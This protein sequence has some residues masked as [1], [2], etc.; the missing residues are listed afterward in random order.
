MQRW[1]NTTIDRLSIKK[2]L[3]NAGTYIVLILAVGGLMFF[4]IFPPQGDQGSLSGTAAEVGDLRIS[5]NDFRAAYQNTHQTYQNQYGQDFDPGRLNLSAIVLNQLVDRA[6]LFLTA[7]ALGVQASEEDVI[8]YLTGIDAFRDKD[9]NFSERYYASFLRSNRYSEEVFMTNIVRDLTLSQLRRFVTNFVFVSRGE[10]E[11]DYRLANSHLDVAFIKIEAAQLNI[12]VSVA[13]VDAYLQTETGKQATQTYFDE[14][15][16]AFKQVEQVQAQHILIA[17]QEARNASGAG[18]KRSKAE[19]QVLATKVRKLAL[20]GAFGALAQ[21]YSDE[22][23]AK[24]RQGDLGFFTREDMAAPFSRAAFALA[25]G[26]ISAVTETDFGFHVIKVLAKK[27]AVEKDF[28]TA[29]PEIG[30]KLLKKERGPEFAARLAQDWLQKLN[31]AI[32]ISQELSA[33]GLKLETTG[34]FSLSAGYVPKL[35]SDTELRDLVYG[36]SSERYALHEQR[37]DFYLL[38]LKAKTLADVKNFKD[39]RSDNEYLR[40]YRGSALYTWLEKHARQ[41]LEARNEISLNNAFLHFD[42]RRAA[43]NAAAQADES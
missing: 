42:Q 24:E 40:F 26:E 32:D 28:N 11:L 15:Q 34:K 31:T 6:A 3:N 13:D 12:T 7:R 19:A 36:L 20:T 9:G 17:H 25:K 27:A 21:Q 5:S 30:K 22:P 2:F 16:S 39:E 18:Q 38:K 8:D 1:K 23:R 43:A 29:Q 14:H 10:A 33:Q 35:G 37:G 41:D 4:G